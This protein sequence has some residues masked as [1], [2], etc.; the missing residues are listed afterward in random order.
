MQRSFVRY[1]NGFFITEFIVNHFAEDLLAWLQYME[2]K[3]TVPA[4]MI[5]AV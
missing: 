2:G 3:C 1:E 4:V 5:K